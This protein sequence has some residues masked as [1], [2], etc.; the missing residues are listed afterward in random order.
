MRSS[1]YSGPCR[2]A[3]TPSVHAQ[4]LALLPSDSP[5]IAAERVEGTKSGGSYRIAA[6]ALKES[7]GQM[8]GSG[9]VEFL[10]F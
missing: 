5:T 8:L 1:G 10:L 6:V 3:G 2:I 4:W 7:H 9:L